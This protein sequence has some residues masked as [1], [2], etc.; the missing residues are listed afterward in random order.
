[1]PNSLT[2]PA[3]PFTWGQARDLGWRHE[4]LAEQ[5]AGGVLERAF[6]NVYASAGSL[7]AMSARAAALALVAR[8]DAVFCDRTA[9]WLHGIDAYSYRELEI[10]PPADC[11]VLSKTRHRVDRAG[12]RGGERDLR[13]EDICVVDGLRV[14]T[15]LRTAM[16]LA[17]VLPRRS[18]L[19]VL[20]GFMRHHG[21]TTAML[22]TMLPRYR[23]R[24]GVVQLRALIPV[25]SPLAES[26][27]ES[28]TRL[29]IL[30][31]NIPAPEPQHW[32]EH[33]GVPLFRLDLAWPKSRVAVE[34]DGEEWHDRTPEQR[35]S[36]RRRRRWLRD[37]GWTVIVVRKHQFSGPARDA[38]L[39]EVRVALGIT[40]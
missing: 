14:T 6:R 18:A 37:H 39:R 13:A 35:A 33:L 11:F 34:Y 20:D 4:G 9:A 32:V 1:M 12:C 28:W 40:W 30:D 25:A 10:L 7:G 31:D 22:V 36:D 23:G 15:P 38:W 19:A 29:E 26:P 8:P 27:A 2:L 21:I 3:S 17:A 5:I 16:D 24:R